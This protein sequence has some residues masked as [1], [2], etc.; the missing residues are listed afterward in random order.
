MKWPERF[1][2]RGGGAET[3]G[4]GRRSDDP[5]F[6]GRMSGEGTV[7]L[8]RWTLARI[9]GWSLK[10]HLIREPHW[11]RCPHDHPWRFWVMP[12][13]GGYIED[14]Q[15][16]R[17]RLRVG[18]IY[19]RAAEHRHRIRSLPKGKS[20]GIVVTAPKSRDWGF[21]TPEGWLKWTRFLEAP[22]ICEDEVPE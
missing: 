8:T 2:I 10:L 14:N 15:D 16:G 18:W 21:H 7:Y 5:S 1:D 9:H 22:P 3:D 17:Q 19:Y 12:I 4:S 20:L 13:W 11:T 6:E